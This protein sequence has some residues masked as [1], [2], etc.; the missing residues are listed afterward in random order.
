MHLYKL[1]NYQ[2]QA[3]K[4]MLEAQN[5]L[6]FRD[7][8][9]I[10]TAGGKSLII[11]DFI[12]KADKPT[13]ILQATQE[14]LSQNREK[15]LQWV[16]SKEVGTYSA[17]FN[18]KEI[19]KFTFATIQSVYKNPSLFAHFHFFIL[20]EAHEKTDMYDNFLKMTKGRKKVYGFSATP[21]R[22][23]REKKFDYKTR[24]FDIQST[25]KMLTQL[26]FDRI[27][28]SI[29]TKELQEQGYLAQVEYQTNIVARVSHNLSSD[30]KMIKNLELKLTFP[31][32]QKF[33]GILH[34]LYEFQSIV[35]FCPTV[36]IATL[37]QEQVSNSAVIDGKTSNKRRKQILQDFKDKSIKILFN[38]G[39]LTTGFDAPNIDC[40]VLARPTG[41][42]V[43]YNQ[44][45]GRG[46]R[47]KE[48]KKPCRV[49]DL[50][51]TVDH[52][53]PLDEIVVLRDQLGKWNTS[54]KGQLQRDRILSIYSGDY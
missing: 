5:E 1:R 23:E 9:H 21:Y 42:L 50:C 24:S 43:L 10:P 15:L 27:I 17:S 46:V 26:T 41:S 2:L 34:Q 49:I 51:G 39:V 35:V 36:R 22:I 18:S 31:A 54:V 48:N 40:I 53:A 12:Q 4:A 29:N 6:E 19:K 37:L 38:V 32:L 14:I 33:R 8:V 47:L 7:I 45:V 11:A 28:Y 16:N 44:I 30:A 3:V 20:D 25:F 52:F 13:I